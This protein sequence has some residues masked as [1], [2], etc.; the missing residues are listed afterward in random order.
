[1]ISVL[2]I[3]VTTVLKGT[4]TCVKTQ[5]LPSLPGTATKKTGSFVGENASKI[6]WVDIKVSASN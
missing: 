5:I 4:F 1:M 2:V 6:G 3:L